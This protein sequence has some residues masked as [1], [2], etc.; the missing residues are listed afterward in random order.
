[1]TGSPARPAAQLSRLLAL[2]PYLRS[3]PGVRLA[4]VAAEFGISE[5]RLRSELDLLWVCGLPGHGPGDLIDFA[6]EGDT[7]TVVEHAGVERPLRLTVDEALALVVALRALAETPGLTARDAVLRALAKIEQAAGD[8]A[9]PA[10]RVAVRV[11]SEE[12]VQPIAEQ[13]LRQGRRLHLSYLVPSRDEVT[14]RDVDPVRIL[15]VDGRAYLEAWCRRAEG[16][17]TFRL[18]RVVSAA[19]LD[20]PAQ[21]PADLEPTDVDHGLFSPPPSAPLVTLALRPE[22]GW[23]AEYY[24]CEQVEVGPDGGL[25]VRLRASD[26]QWARRLVLRLGASVRVV[27]PPELAEQVRAEAALALAAYDPDSRSEQPTT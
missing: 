7:V 1:M 16:L 27:D 4:A 12:R 15:F 21:P 10:V 8:A 2:L 20:E 23:V 14:E 24:P 3:H 5:E 9:L 11:E 6:F 26:A 22:A 25:L 17:R 19:L 13:A 18:D